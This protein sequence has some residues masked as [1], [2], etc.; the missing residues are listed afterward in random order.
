MAY[1]SKNYIYNDKLSAEENLILDRLYKL[2]MSSMSEALEQQF[3]N[4]NCDLENFHTRLAAIIN[5]EWEQRQT[6]KFNTFMQNHKVA[7]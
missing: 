4:P 6:K 2:R 7:L 1:K 5:Y 3:T